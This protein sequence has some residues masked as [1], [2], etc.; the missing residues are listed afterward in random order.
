MVL[1]CLPAS[2]CV[3]CTESNIRCH[4]YNSF[5]NIV[6]EVTKCLLELP[7]FLRMLLHVASCVVP[8]TTYLQTKNLHLLLT[9]RIQF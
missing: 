4:Y 3:L 2:F 1:T 6:Q 9:Y 8:V 7:L 5:C